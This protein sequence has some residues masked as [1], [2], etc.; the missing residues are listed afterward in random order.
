MHLRH[1]HHFFIILAI[2]FFLIGGLAYQVRSCAGHTIT[3]VPCAGLGQ[4]SVIMVAWPLLG[5]LNA[6]N[7]QWDMAGLAGIFVLGVAGSLYAADFSRRHL[8]KSKNSRA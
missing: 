2:A 8:L 5:L 3:N 7:G 1:H 4:T 6:L